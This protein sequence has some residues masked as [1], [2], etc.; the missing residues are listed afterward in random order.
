MTAQDLFPALTK[1]LQELYGSAPQAQTLA[2]EFANIKNAFVDMADNI[3]Q[4]GGSNALKAFA[5]GAQAALVF[6]DASLVA[7][8]QKI[9]VLMGAVSTLDFSGV[10]DAF[11][12]IESEAQTKL[13]KAAQ[14]NELLRASLQAVGGEATQAALAVQQAAGQADASAVSYQALGAAYK[15]VRD[16]LAQ[17][18]DLSERDVKAAKARGDA[19]VAQARLLG[20]EAALRAAIGQ[21]AQG[22][23]QA[24]ATLAQQRQTEVD[25]LRAELDNKKA[26]LATAGTLSE[27]RTKELQALEAL[28]AQSISMPMRRPRKPPPPRPAP[29]PR[30]GGTGRRTSP[31][32]GAGQ[33]GG[34]QVG[35]RRGGQP[36][37][38]PARAGAAE[39]ADGAPDGR[40]T[41]VR[42][43]RIRQMEIDAQITR[44]K[45]EA[46]RVEAEEALRWPRP[47][48]RKWLPRARPMR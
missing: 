3:G 2:Q 7:T 35:R 9:G 46:Q 33:R 18:I 22:E 23:A 32:G 1:G 34:A 16:E 21:A 31:R 26:L 48:W 6:L 12:Q 27:E 5:E 8:G 41:S 17:Q 44:A 45:A 13:A 4:A 29:A 24:L 38:T 19:A 14:H 37:A 10:K 40:R 39:R 30:G 36:A 43:E 25:V 11:A 42:R 15:K 28:V 47:R 20:D